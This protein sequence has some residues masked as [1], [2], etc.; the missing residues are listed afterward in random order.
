MKLVILKYIDTLK[1][2]L[3]LNILFIGVIILHWWYTDI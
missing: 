2:E 1:I 3:K